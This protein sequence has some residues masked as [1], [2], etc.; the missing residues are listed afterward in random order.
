MWEG[1]AFKTSLVSLEHNNN[2]KT[3]GK[4]PL[5]G[6]TQPVL[7]L[8]QLHTSINYQLTNT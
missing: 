4:E 6:Q 5:P 3:L 2:H 8:M 1:K 7:L